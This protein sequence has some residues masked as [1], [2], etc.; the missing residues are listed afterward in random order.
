MPTKRDSS[1]SPAFSRWSMAR[2][3][4]RAHRATADSCSAGL[5]PWAKAGDDHLIG[6]LG[7]VEEGARSRTG[8]RLPRS[9]RGPRR[10]ASLPRHAHPYRF[11]RRGSDA[12]LGRGSFRAAAEL[13]DIAGAPLRRASALPRGLAG[14]RDRKAAAH[15]RCVCPSTERRRRKITT[16]IARISRLSG[17]KAWFIMSGLYPAPGE[18]EVLRRSILI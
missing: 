13:I 14:I 1:F 4:R 2:E 10:A 12:C 18:F 17:S 15:C 8:D 9:S 11:G 16:A 3:S 6:H 5:S 7:A